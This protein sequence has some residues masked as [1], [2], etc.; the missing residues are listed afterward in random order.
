[1]VEITKS[2]RIDLNQFKLHMSCKPDIELTLHFDSPSRKFYLSVI[3]LV[4][5]EMKTKKKITS[6]LLQN[7]LD[8]IVL[9]NKTVGENAGSSKKEQLLHRIYRKWKDALPDLENAP[10]FK[11]VG[12]KKSFDE[13]RDK[14]YVFNEEEKDCWANLF[15][16][17][18][19]YENVRLRFSIDKLSAGLEDVA[20]VY[21]DSPGLSDA[22]AWENFLKN[23]KQSQEEQLSTDSVDQQFFV[24]EP[25]SKPEDRAIIQK[26]RKWLMRFTIV[27]LI[28]CFTAFV[29]WQYNI[30]S[31]KIEVASI[32]KLAFPL[33]EKPSIAVLPFN[34]M[35]GDPGNEYLSDGITENIITTLSKTDKLFVISR[36]STFTYKGKPVKVK[37]VAEELGVRYVLEGSV[38]KNE[39]KVRITAQL[40]DAID[41]H[42]LWAEHYDSDIENIFALQD[43][44][45]MKIASALQIQLTEGEQFRMMSKQYES[46]DVLL[47][48]M[49]CRSLWAKGDQKSHIRYGQVAQEI[50]DMAPESVVG[51]RALAWHYWGLVI[52]GKSPQE[53][54][55]KAFRLAQKALSIDESDSMTYAL[56]GSVYLLMRKYEK[57]IAAGE[58][59]VELEPNG[60]MAHGLL[61]NTLS[62]VER[63]DEAIGYLK[64]GI[65][66]N[67]FPEYW[68][69]YHLGRCYIMKGQYEEAL[70]ATKKAILL[71][72]DS[73]GNYYNL[74]AI[75]TLLGRQDEASAAVKKVLE[76]DPNFSVERVSKSWPYKS[77]ADLKLFVDALHKAG[78]P[79]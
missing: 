12:R 67:P 22:D 15:E 28:V 73:R 71:A 53:N 34:N 68:N 42:H 65:R 5:I 40:I 10:L 46:L 45:T 49:E 77:K 20:I 79:D 4:I 59:S 33:P 52:L 39:D 70:A 26:N 9:L 14:V 76:L 55:E 1:M 50:I 66:L 63:L 72:P 30:F 18:G 37:Q 60:A 74:A 25:M 19:S 11:V 7:H 61:G 32:E 31:L 38:Q 43:E 56:L 47:K 58:R 64:Q 3:A 75:Y 51:Y 41:G 57:A 62:Y 29:L 48:A 23:L 8:E 44:I 21:G 16:Y 78:L 54:I 13:L 2:I 35:S 6:I 69:F 27:G 17:K 24:P 36:N